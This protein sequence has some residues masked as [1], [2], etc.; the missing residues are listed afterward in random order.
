MV[1]FPPETISPSENSGEGG[2]YAT[3]LTKA[4]PCEEIVQSNFGGGDERCFH[5]RTVAS[6]EAEK[7]KLG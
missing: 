1:S 7:M 4:E 5:M 3:V 2:M 6:L